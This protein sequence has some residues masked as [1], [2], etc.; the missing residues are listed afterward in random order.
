[1]ENKWY[2]DEIYE[3]VIVRPIK[4]L[5]GFFERYVERGV[6]DALVNG[7]GKS[8]HFGSRQLRLLQSG[9]VGSYVLLMIVG[10]VLLFVLQ[11]LIKK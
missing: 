7:V 11:Y 10:I 9:Q 8:V 4:A 5:G 1:L 2:V 3:S 6:V